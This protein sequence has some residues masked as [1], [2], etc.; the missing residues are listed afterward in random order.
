[1]MSW[2]GLDAPGVSPVAAIVLA[3]N[4][5]IVEVFVAPREEDLEHQV[6]VR[7]TRSLRQM[8]GLMLRK[9]MHN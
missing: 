4:M 1:M 7:Q 9:T 8:S 3:K 6:E 5:E 2:C